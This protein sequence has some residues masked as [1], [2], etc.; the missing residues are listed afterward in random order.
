MTHKPI[1][2]REISLVFPERICFLGFSFV[3]RPGQRIAV[4]GNNGAGKSTLLKM[5]INQREPSD[6][7]ISLPDNLCVGYVPQVVEEDLCLSGG[8]AF[9]HLLS[10]AQASSPDIL[11]LDEPTNHLDQKNRSSLMRM[12]KGFLGTVIVATHDAE[13]L[14]SDFDIIWS[15]DEG[16]VT[17]FYGSF[18]DFQ[19]EFHHQRASLEAEVRLL[20][21]ES[22]QVHESTMKEQARAKSSRKMGE[23]NVDQRKWPTVVSKAKLRRAQETTGRKKAQLTDKKAELRDQLSRL[24]R[25]EVITPK[26]HIAADLSKKAELLSVAGGSIGY[27]TTLIDSIYLTL[28]VGDRIAITGDNGS[29]K[30]TLLKAFIDDPRI[31]KTGSWSLPKR[32]DIGYLD[33]NYKNLHVNKTVLNTIWDIRPDFSLSECRR[34]LND[35]LFRKN[36]EV[37]K[38]VSVLSGGELMRLSLCLIA[39]SAPRLLVVDEITNNVDMETKQHITQVLNQYQGALV[40]IS[41]DENFLKSLRLQQVLTIKNG[42][43]H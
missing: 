10:K 12:L 17:V 23:K 33:Q 37:N 6:G 22:K 43:I 18:Q 21:K 5:L 39:A 14:R 32:D 26:F 20:N 24:K 31:T 9:N 27:D 1:Y 7:E 8:Q 30:S 38:S 35:F 15:L 2:I 16:R 19:R 42:S 4:V 13:L 25:P 3:V 29:G 34:H 40:V 11:I 41:H 36:D 28:R